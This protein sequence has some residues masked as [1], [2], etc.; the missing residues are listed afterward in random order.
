[1]QSFNIGCA[2]N[3]QQYNLLNN[4]QLLRLW[5]VAAQAMWLGTQW[6]CQFRD[7]SYARILFSW[8]RM[9]ACLMPTHCAPV[10]HHDFSILYSQL[11]TCGVILHHCSNDSISIHL[12]NVHPNNSLHGAV[13]VASWQAQRIDKQTLIMTPRISF[14][15]S[16][17]HRL[18]FIAHKS[19]NNVRAN[20]K[21][22]DCMRWFV[23]LQRTILK[24]DYQILNKTK[25]PEF[26]NWHIEPKYIKSDDYFMCV[27][28]F[29]CS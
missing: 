17:M 6:Y 8:L 19:L 26:N 21:M 7:E 12:H 22:I 5:N 1:M 2:L 14:G 15:V 29:G 23:N 3:T 20:V 27:A 13:V 9:A 10:L 28:L 11:F 4:I 16:A 24:R 18:C 25:T